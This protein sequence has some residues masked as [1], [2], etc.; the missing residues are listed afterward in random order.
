MI[1]YALHLPKVGTVTFTVWAHCGEDG[2]CP[3]SADFNRRKSA[4][5]LCFD[6]RK[7]QIF[8]KEPTYYSKLKVVRHVITATDI[9]ELRK[10]YAD[11]TS[12]Y[13]SPLDL[14][15]TRARSRKRLN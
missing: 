1:N 8:G 2:W 4:Q 13:A 12:E 3:I 6:L 9:T 14:W 11:Y 10:E 5:R 15:L 7:K